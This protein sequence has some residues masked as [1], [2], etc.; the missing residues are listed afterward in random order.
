MKFGSIQLLRD[1][2]KSRYA[3]FSVVQSIFI[4]Q[5]F[6]VCHRVVQETIAKQR[7]L[8]AFL[9]NVRMMSEG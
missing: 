9:Q 8:H 1:N 6:D 7:I 5:K 2:M 4:G 3:N